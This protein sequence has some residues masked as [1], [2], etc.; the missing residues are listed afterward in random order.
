[1]SELY[2]MY[3]EKFFL[4]NFQYFN[5]ILDLVIIRKILAIVNKSLIHKFSLSTN[6][7]FNYVKI[8]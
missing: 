7:T 3:H 5:Y 6:P 8:R 4:N 1:M 2:E